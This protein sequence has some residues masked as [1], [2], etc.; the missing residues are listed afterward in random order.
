M[1]DSLGEESSLHIHRLNSVLAFFLLELVGQRL[2][3]AYAFEIQKGHEALVLA[4]VAH[5]M[6]RVVAVFAH[7]NIVA[8]H[9]A[10]SAHLHLQEKSDVHKSKVT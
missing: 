2:L 8:D 3:H 5:N 7:I 4:A 1:L 10:D 6:V 9:V